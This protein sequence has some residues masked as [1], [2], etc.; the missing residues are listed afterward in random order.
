MYVYVIEEEGCMW[1]DAVQVYMHGYGKSVMKLNLSHAQYPLP[2]L[3]PHT[4][5]NHLHS[6]KHSLSSKH[7]YVKLA[8]SNTLKMLKWLGIDRATYSGTTLAKNLTDGICQLLI[9]VLTHWNW[10][11]MCNN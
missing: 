5:S 10:V 6:S 8:I 2:L 4:D 3:L 9:N 11:K 7:G 1:I